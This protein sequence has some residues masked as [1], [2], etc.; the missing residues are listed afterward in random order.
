MIRGDHQ[1]A[2]FLL[3]FSYYCTEEGIFQR[4][5]L[6]RFEIMKSET[7]V[8]KIQLRTTRF[9]VTAPTAISDTQ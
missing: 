1:R 6:M 8:I 9:T 3:L 5:S 2:P 7:G 4:I